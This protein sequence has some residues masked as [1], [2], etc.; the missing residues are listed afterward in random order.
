MASLLL[1][2]TCFSL[3]QLRRGMLMCLA[4]LALGQFQAPY[5]SSRAGVPPASPT[6][7]PPLRPPPHADPHS[8]RIFIMLWV[9]HIETQ[10][11]RTLIA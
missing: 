6:K 8:F 7:S 1:L 11:H 2:V 9:S 10:S 5:C 4:Q 3:G